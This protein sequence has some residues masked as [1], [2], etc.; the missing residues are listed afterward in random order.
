MCADC[1]VVCDF[2]LAERLKASQLVLDGGSTTSKI[3][4]KEK[5][6]DE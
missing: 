1:K 3:I 5:N 6:K 2:L 4:E